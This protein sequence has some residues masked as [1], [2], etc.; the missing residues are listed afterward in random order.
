MGSV[1]KGRGINMEIRIENTITVNEICKLKKIHDSFFDL[2][3]NVS[4]DGD[5]VYFR[6]N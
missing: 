4:I 3:F 1:S 5:Y 6:N 2:D